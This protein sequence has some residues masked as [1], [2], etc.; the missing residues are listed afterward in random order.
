VLKEIMHIGKFAKFCETG[1]PI[2]LSYL[3]TKQHSS[4]INRFVAILSLL[5]TVLWHSHEF[6]GRHFSHPLDVV[7]L[8]YQQYKFCIIN[9]LMHALKN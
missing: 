6:I 1:V 4:I 7:H 2:F 9:A 5:S 3:M 8:Q